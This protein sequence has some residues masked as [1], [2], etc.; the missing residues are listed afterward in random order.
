MMLPLL[1]LLSGRAVAQEFRGTISGT[2]TDATGAVVKD[3]RVTITETSTNTINRTKTDSAGQYVVPFLQPGTYQIVVEMAS[4]KKDVRNG[5]TLQANEHPLIDMTLQAGNAQETIS[6]TEDAPLVDTA[7]ASAGQVIT[8]KE[9]EDY[10][11]NGRTPITL[12]E[13]AVGVVPSSQPSQIHHFDNSGASNW[14]IGG[15]PAQASEVLLDG[16][17]DTTWQGDV[18][19]NPPQGVVKELSISFSDTDA[20]YGHTI[21]GVMNQITMSGTNKLLGSV[22]EFHVIPSLAANTYFNKRTSP[23]QTL[24]PQKFDQYGLTIG[25]PVLTPKL[26]D[27]RNKVFFFFFFGHESLPDSN[28]STTTNTVPTDAERKGDFSAPLPLGCPNGYLGTDYSH[29][30]N[31]SANPYQLYRHISGHD[32]NPQTD[33]EQ[34]SDQR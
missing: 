27:G 21:G 17:P 22:Y 1:L 25:G 11:V 8:T 33:S 7:N 34:Y 30:A 24:P 16:T 31:G 12:V 10:P 28:P 26:F 5:V 6:V 29:C 32:G 19:Y 23:I 9:V 2:V 3:A 14:S 15:T 20:S 13:L 18:A 4:F